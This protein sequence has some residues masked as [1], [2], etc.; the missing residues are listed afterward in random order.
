[1]KE[2]IYTLP[3]SLL[4]DMTKK[5]RHDIIGVKDLFAM[6]RGRY[7]GKIEFSKKELQ[8][9]IDEQRASFK[10][11]TSVIKPENQ[12]VILPARADAAINSNSRNNLDNVPDD[13][14]SLDIRN[15]AQLMEFFQKKLLEKMKKTEGSFNSNDPYVMS[16]WV[17]LLKESY[18]IIEKQIKLQLEI[19]NSSRL[20][21]LVNERFQ[22]VIGV[23]FAAVQ[24]HTNKEVFGKIKGE[25]IEALNIYKMPSDEQSW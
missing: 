4:A 16:I 23:F 2:R 8:E 12:Q 10:Q 11:G 9:W 14:E 24:K 22:I 6:I 19:E 20:D 25:I 13:I 5:I 7:K 3:E 21:T 17:S 1:V 18:T 15:K